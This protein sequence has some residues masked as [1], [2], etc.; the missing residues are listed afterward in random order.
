ME[1]VEIFC[2]KCKGEIDVV[3]N[4]PI[5][6]PFNIEVFEIESDSLPLPKRNVEPENRYCCDKCSFCFIIEVEY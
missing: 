6:Q 4:K 5:F 2:P 1:S 3:N